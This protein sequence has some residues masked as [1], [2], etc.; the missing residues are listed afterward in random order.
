[1]KAAVAE[2]STTSRGLLSVLASVYDPLGIVEP[3]TSPA[4]ILLQRLAKAKRDWDVEIPEEAKSTWES[5][6]RTLPTLDGLSIPRVYTGFVDAKDIQ[7]HFFADA[8]KD[9]YGAVYYVRC[10]DGK[11]YS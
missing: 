9:G 2:H 3:F 8:S 11:E 7:L 10:Y 5:W 1:M 4:K 6:L